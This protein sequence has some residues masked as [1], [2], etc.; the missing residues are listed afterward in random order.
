[1]HKLA[2]KYKLKNRKTNVP[3][4]DMQ[5][6]ESTIYSNTQ[7]DTQ[8]QKSINIDDSNSI[9]RDINE[10]IQDEE[11]NQNV[12]DLS[13]NFVADSVSDLTISQ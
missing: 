1:M 12:D 5:N 11:L 9:N 3:L 8:S 2:D 10:I 7:H 13:S 4:S 6:D